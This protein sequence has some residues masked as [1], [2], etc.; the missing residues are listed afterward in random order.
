MPV[1]NIPAFMGANGMPIG[2]SV[3]PGR[4]LD[5]KLLGICK[6]L[7]EPLMTE[8]GWKVERLDSTWGTM[9]LEPDFGYNSTL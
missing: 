7:S 2:L 3:V 8:G 1:L 9:T 4:F 6:V 5:Q